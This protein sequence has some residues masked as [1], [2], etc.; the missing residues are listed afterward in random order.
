M[1]LVEK[2]ADFRPDRPAKPGPGLLWP[3]FAG[4]RG[5]LAF[6]AA[7]GLVLIAP[8][9][10]TPI[11]LALLIDE[12]LTARVAAPWA[13]IGGEAPVGRDGAGFAQRLALSGGTGR[14]K[15]PQ[16]K[17]LRNR[18]CTCTLASSS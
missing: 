3:W 14:R 6:A 15:S 9:L 7:A 16:K 12:V 10:A 1:L 13:L 8:T 18:M 17:R 5:P 11:L 4:A 2:T